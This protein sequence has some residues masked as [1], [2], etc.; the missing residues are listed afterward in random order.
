MLGERAPKD[1]ADDQRIDLPHRGHPA[2]LSKKFQVLLRRQDAAQ[3][4]A[5]FELVPAGVQGRI[6][7]HGDTDK[8]DLVEN[9]AEALRRPPRRRGWPPRLT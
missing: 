2:I 5:Q 9:A 1:M 8:F 3:Q 4:G 7:E 6:G